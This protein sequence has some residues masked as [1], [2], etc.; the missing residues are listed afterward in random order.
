MSNHKTYYSELCPNEPG[1]V[2]EQLAREREELELKIKSL[3]KENA[4][5]LNEVNTWFTYVDPF[6][7]YPGHTEMYV[8]RVATF[9]PDKTDI[10]I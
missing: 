4:S 5:L 8:R 1:W 9:E 3:Q 10:K 7:M 2:H 6:D